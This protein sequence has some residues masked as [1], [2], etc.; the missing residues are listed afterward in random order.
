MFDFA[1]QLQLEEQEFGHLALNSVSERR[2]AE[3]SEE[4]DNFFEATSE[5]EVS[6]DEGCA[7]VLEPADLC[8][9]PGAAAGEAEV[10]LNP[11]PKTL[12]PKPS[13]LNPQP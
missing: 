12:N 8:V 2:L 4:A 1:S 9:E 5:A 3:K 10:A 11:T 13:T 6:D 7:S